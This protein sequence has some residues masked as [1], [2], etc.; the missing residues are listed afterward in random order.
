MTGK[1][2]IKV[3]GIGGA[4]GNAID[5]M[6]MCDMKGI[7]LIAMNTD[8]QDLKKIKANQHNIICHVINIIILHLKIIIK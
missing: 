4:G 5:R 3:I 7:D 1:T 2:A 6:M 8:A